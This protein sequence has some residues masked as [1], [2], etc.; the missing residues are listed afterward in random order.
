MKIEQKGEGIDTINIITF[1]DFDEIQDFY[2]VVDMS[3]NCRWLENED[4]NMVNAIGIAMS[5]ARAILGKPILYIPNELSYDDK[6]KTLI[7]RLYEC[8]CLYTSEIRDPESDACGSF[9]KIANTFKR[10]C[11]KFLSNLNK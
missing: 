11:K 3:A 8:C 1:K 7:D 9:K 5:I 10:H 6:D 2:E 4:N